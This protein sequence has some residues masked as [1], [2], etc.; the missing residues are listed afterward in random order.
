MASTAQPNPGPD[1]FH[2]ER[3]KCIDAFASLEEAIVLLLDAM[4]IEF[5]A[6]SFGQKIG[7]M[8]NAK[9]GPQ[10]SQ[11]RMQSVHNVLQ[12]CKNLGELRNDIV[13]SRLQIA[14]FDTETRACFTNTRQC[15]S[16]SQSAR[17]FTLAGLR[18]VTTEATQLAEELRRL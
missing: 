8:Q 15:L 14:S 10:F 16:G 7:L 3:S 9:A 11:S 18:S 1:A 17:L 6:E 13:H 4:K 5:G 2:R 12:R